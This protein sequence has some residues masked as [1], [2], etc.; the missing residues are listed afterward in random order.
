MLEIPLVIAHGETD[1][2]LV[3]TTSVLGSNQPLEDYVIA[4][5]R[6]PA[7]LEATTGS[8]LFG[9]AIDAPKEYKDGAGAAVSITFAADEFV[10]LKPSDYPFTPPFVG[11]SLGTA[12]TNPGSSRTVHLILAKR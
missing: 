4:G 8:L 2:A 6:T 11:I 9:T 1:S 10:R 3:A 7:G 5:L 12:V